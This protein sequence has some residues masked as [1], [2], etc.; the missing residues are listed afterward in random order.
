MRNINNPMSKSLSV[1]K[2]SS[3]MLNIH[4]DTKSGSNDTRNKARSSINVLGLEQGPISINL[5]K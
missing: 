5:R 1:N 3:T 2:R 4:I